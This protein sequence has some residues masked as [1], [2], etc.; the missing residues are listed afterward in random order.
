[1][2]VDFEKAGGLVPAIAQDAQ[3]W[4]EQ[5]R[6]ETKAEPVILEPGGCLNLA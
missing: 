6:K 5:V 3:A 4:A 2:S 1:M